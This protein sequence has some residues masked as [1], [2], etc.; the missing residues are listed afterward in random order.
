MT[1]KG[2]WCTWF[3]SKAKWVMLKSLLTL[4][5]PTVKEL[6]FNDVLLDGRAWGC[7]SVC[8]IGC[9]L[10]RNVWN[11]LLKVVCREILSL[12]WNRRT[13]VKLK[14][15]SSRNSWY[16]TRHH[17]M[18]HINPPW[19]QSLLTKVLSM[20]CFQWA[21]LPWS[22]LPDCAGS[23]TFRAFSPSCAKKNFL[24]CG[25]SKM[26]KMSDLLGLRM[27]ILCEI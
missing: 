26:R 9:D 24:L 16:T 2:F 10:V 15:L 20:W 22:A 5:W 1:L 13:F 12:G 25:I 21:Q 23:R 11:Q 6:F 27:R 17:I 8:P 19:G 18:E 7:Q 4:M 3:S 14:L